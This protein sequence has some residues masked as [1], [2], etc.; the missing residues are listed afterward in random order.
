[1]FIHLIIFLAKFFVFP[2]LEVKRVG[3]YGPKPKNN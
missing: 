1:M 2:F 3:E